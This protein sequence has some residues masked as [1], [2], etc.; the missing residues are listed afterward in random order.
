MTRGSATLFALSLIGLIV[1]LFMAVVLVVSAANESRRTQHVADLAALAAADVDQG[2]APGIACA[3]ARQLV[4][5]MASGSV[6]CAVDSGVAQVIVTSEWRGIE[7]TKRA[8][9]RP[10]APAR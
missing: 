5:R 2:V 9:A 6:S 7:I 4:I 3:F 10:F 1:S 8:S